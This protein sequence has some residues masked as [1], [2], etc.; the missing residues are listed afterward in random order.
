MRLSV[1]IKT[2]LVV[3]VLLSPAV[4]AQEPK[5]PDYAHVKI[6]LTTEGGPCGCVYFQDDRYVG[7]CPKYSVSVDENGTVIYNGISGVKTRGERV[8]SIPVT[9]VRDVVA[10]FYRIGFFSLQDRYEVKK[11]PNGDYA[12]VD[13]SNAMTISIDI[14]GKTKSVYI[15]YGA[16]QELADLLTKIVEVTRVAQYVGGT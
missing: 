14:D 16:P 15:F 9:T 6:T 11:L 1:L 4:V 3:F 2:I 13:H 5:A 10:D 7:C 12:T 8:L